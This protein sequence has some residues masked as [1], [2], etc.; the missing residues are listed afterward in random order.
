MKALCYVKE[1]RYKKPDLNERSRR[2]KPR[3]R[4]NTD[5]CRGPERAG[6][7]YGEGLLNGQFPFGVMEMLW[8]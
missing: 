3:D 7:K 6:G 8:N 1:A 4:K 2:G 5:G